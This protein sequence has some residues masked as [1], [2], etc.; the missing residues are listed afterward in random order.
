MAA[1]EELLKEMSEDGKDTLMLIRELSSFVAYY[2]RLLDKLELD[3]LTGLPGSNKYQDLKVGIEKRMPAV[4]VV[5]FDV[6][7]LKYYN[8]VKGHQAGDQLLQKAAE[9]FHAV[10]GPNVQIFRTGGD[11]F[12]G[13]ITACVQSDIDGVIA[14]WQKRLVELNS[15]DDG[16][17]CNIAHGTAFGSGEY[18]FSDIMALADERMYA[19]KRWMKENGQKIG[20][21]R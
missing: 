18:R 17:R 13:I 9:S 7:D 1:V 5:V 6:N 11:E 12:V 21:I 20:N 16:I 3:T 19:H 4:G 2:R 10:T 15:A 14:K 8:D